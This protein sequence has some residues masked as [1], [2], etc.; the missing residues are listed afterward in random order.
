MTHLKAMVN[1]LPLLYRNGELV[2]DML[3]VP[4]VELDILDEEALEVQ[5]AHWFDAALTL[6]EAGKLAAVL[7]LAPEPWQDLGEFRAWVHALRNARLQ[8][9]SVTQRAIANFV[10]DYVRRYQAAV[11]IRAIPPIN[12]WQVS[13]AIY[14]DDIT[15]PPDPLALGRQV[16]RLGPAIV[17]TPPKRQYERIPL[18]G[19]L[20]PLQSFELVNDGLDDSR[21]GLLLTGLADGPEHVPL[22][23]NVTTGEGLLFLGE[24]PPGQRLWLRPNPDGSVTAEL[25]K[26]DVTAQLRSIANLQPGV[27]WTPEQ[28]RD[29]I[30]LTLR[31]GANTLWFLPVAHYDQR[32][33]DRFLFSLPDLLLHQGLYDQVNFDQALFYQEP[34]IALQATW[35]E[36]QP[37][38]FSVQLPAAALAH[39]PGAVQAAIAS[40]D[41]LH[42]SLNQGVAKL[43]PAGVAAHVEFQVFSEIQAQADY[44]TGV[45]PI[46]IQEIGPTGSDQLLEVGGLF[47][48]TEFDDSTFR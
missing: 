42:A 31:S 20:Q 37:A 44:M 10:A 13:T 32:G 39:P 8:D 45:S 16:H 43:K 23:V 6:E 38:R 5:R 47:S 36:T 40:Y 30:A 12:R 33:L 18:A 19:G 2:E 11:G 35:I 9:G 41:E 17:D 28:L 48:V 34:A 46:Q 25:E 24:V 26:R 29:P 7:D 15:P 14:G 22:V 21:L 4:A 3:A 1:R 27:P